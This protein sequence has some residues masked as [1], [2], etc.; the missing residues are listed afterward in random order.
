MQHNH[1]VEGVA[2]RLRPVVDADA[3]L[4][5]ALRSNPALNRF[6]HASSDAI[7]DQLNWLNAYKTRAGDYYFVVERITDGRPEGVISLYD[8]DPDTRQGEWG[9][10][11]LQPGSLAAVE[12]AWLIYRF[13]FNTLGLESVFC[14]TVAE[15]TSVVSF[16][17][18]CG[19]D[20]RRL[21]AA[22]FT[23]NGR[24]FDAVEHTV[25]RKKWTEIQARLQRLAQLAARSMSR[26]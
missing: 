22:Q 20:D 19:I 23:L 3:A 1:H 25:S 5:V 17:D 4:I 2:L 6:L 14:R 7:Q 9:R 11:I 12:S 21:L 15:N 18:S 26:G 24:A 10:W 13:A 8:I 16:H